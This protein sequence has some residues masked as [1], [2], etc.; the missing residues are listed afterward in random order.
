MIAGACKPS[1]LRN[2][3]STDC[4]VPTVLCEIICSAVSTRAKSWISLIP[5]CSSYHICSFFE[6]KL[7]LCGVLHILIASWPVT[8][9]IWFELFLILSELV[10]E[11]FL[12]EERLRKYAKHGPNNPP[13][14]RTGMFGAIEPQPPPTRTLRPLIL[15]SIIAYSKPVISTWHYLSIT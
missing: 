12:L 11:F 3:W 6:A 8:G 10:P 14:Q 15:P 5:L 13:Q 9:M 4:F 2:L 7:T 1:L